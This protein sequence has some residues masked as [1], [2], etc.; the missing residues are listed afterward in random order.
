MA[1][2]AAPT[3]TASGPNRAPYNPHDAS[4]ISNLV[5]DVSPG[6]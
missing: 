2:N 1:E 6:Q 5:V 3:F 4:I